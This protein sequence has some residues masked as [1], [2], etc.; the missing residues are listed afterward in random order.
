MIGRTGIERN[1]KKTILTKSKKEQEVVKSHD[2]TCSEVM[3]HMEKENLK[4]G[5]MSF[6]G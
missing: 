6:V 2:H 4:L 5:N 1:I 3:Q